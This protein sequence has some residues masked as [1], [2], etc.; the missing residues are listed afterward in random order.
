MYVGPEALS[1]P[2]L[3]GVIDFLRANSEDL[4]AYLAYHSFSQFWMLPY[5]YTKDKIPKHYDEMVRSIAIFFWW[6]KWYCVNNL[7]HPTI[8]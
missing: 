1:E 4:R 8:G 5:S 2:E 6:T 3:R 7:V